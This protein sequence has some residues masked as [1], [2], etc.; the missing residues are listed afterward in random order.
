LFKILHD[1]REYGCRKINFAG[2]EPFMYPELLGDMVQYCKEV[3]KYESVSIISNASKIQERWFATYGQYIDI[4]GVSCDA[5]EDDVNKSI[6]RGGGN[7]TKF[8]HR[9]AAICRLY[10]IPF[11]LNTVVNAYNVD[12][13]LGTLVNELQPMRWKVFQ[14]LG[15]TGENTGEDSLRDVSRF[16]I[17]DEK[18]QSYIERNRKQLQNPEIL[19]VEDNSTM[20]SSYILV[21]EYGCFLDCSGGGKVATRSILDVGVRTAFHELLQ[22]SGGGFDR[23]AFIRRDGDYASSS[24]SRER[25]QQ[26]QQ[27]QPPVPNR[28]V[29]GG[30]CGS[31]RERPTIDI[32]DLLTR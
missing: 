32:E 30:G 22:S 3:L 12:K 21:D 11:K 2:G 26:M 8:V 23:D 13:D 29:G 19:K 20:Q 7:H 31:G 6:G 5:V 10:N 24:W 4:L 25:M 16:L 27:M 17:S 18:F 28:C 9:A 15:L 14:V 1:L